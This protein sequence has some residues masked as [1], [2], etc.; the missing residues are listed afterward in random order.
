MTYNQKTVI[1][2]AIGVAVFYFGCVRDSRTDPA[3]ERY[4]KT[5]LMACDAADE[6]DGHVEVK[7]WTEA[8]KA[9]R[10]TI[11][12]IDTAGSHGLQNKNDDW[13]KEWKQA[14]SHYRLMVRSIDAA[15]CR[16][17]ETAHQFARTLLM[18]PFKYIE[19]DHPDPYG[20]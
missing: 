5:I 15:D 1:A 3:N 20:R 19:V 12:L 11:S 14:Q 9:A 7:N 6:T 16:K 2:F 10:Q 4:K 17:A 18:N 8:S 13:W